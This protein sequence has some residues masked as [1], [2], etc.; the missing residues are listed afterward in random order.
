MTAISDKSERGR[1]SPGRG[2]ALDSATRAAGAML[3]LSGPLSILMGAAGIAEDSLFATS[4]GY[5]YNFPLTAWGII[6]LAIGVAL[7]VAGLGLLAGK[8]WGRGA[9]VVTA[10]VSLITQFMFVPFYPAWAIPVMALDLLILFAL[11][12]SHIEAAR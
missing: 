9:G 3:M 4:N 8:S 2:H 10:G 5:A 7:S 1:G 6:H 12:R 11:T